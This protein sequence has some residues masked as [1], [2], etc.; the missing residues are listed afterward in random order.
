MSDEIKTRDPD[1]DVEFAGGKP[2]H[3]T[4]SHMPDG[5]YRLV[6][7][8]DEPTVS[9]KETTEPMVKPMGINELIEKLKPMVDG[10]VIAFIE[11]WRSRLE[12]G[13]C[14]RCKMLNSAVSNPALIYTPTKPP[15]LRFEREIQEGGRGIKIIFYKY[16]FSTKSEVGRVR[17]TSKDQCIDFAKSLGLQAEFME[18]A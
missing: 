11:K 17:F 14:P 10:C 3:W 16:E 4:T 1:Y 12:E 2:F 7:I 5:K 6:K 13:M 18:G 9:K 8:S 15:P